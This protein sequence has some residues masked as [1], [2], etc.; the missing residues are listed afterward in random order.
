[1]CA[2]FAYVQLFK[3]SLFL[4]TTIPFPNFFL[5]KR[6]PLEISLYQTNTKSFQVAEIF[7]KLEA[8]TKNMV[9]ILAT[10]NN[11]CLMF[12]CFFPYYLLMLSGEELFVEFRWC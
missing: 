7:N 11:K 3:G 12:Q 5:I 4:S 2:Y 1:M 8:N 10:N 6:K 9:D